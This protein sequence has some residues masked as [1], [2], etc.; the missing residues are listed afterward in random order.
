MQRVQRSTF[1]PGLRGRL[2]VARKHHGAL[3]VPED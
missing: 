3:P 2:V 1:Q